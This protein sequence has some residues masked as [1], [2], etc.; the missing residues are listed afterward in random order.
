MVGG[1]RRLVSAELRR[2]LVC[3]TA[4]IALMPA[5]GHA[6]VDAGLRAAHGGD[7][8]AAVREWQPL[9]KKTIIA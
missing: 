3:I 2:C 5:V 4:L 1:V 9:L 8:G 6:D 7:Y